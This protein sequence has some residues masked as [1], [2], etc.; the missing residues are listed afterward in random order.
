LVTPNVYNTTKHDTSGNLN[1]SA[2]LASLKTTKPQNTLGKNELVSKNGVA[3]GPLKSKGLVYRNQMIGK[4]KLDE[5]SPE[6]NID[7]PPRSYPTQ[8][9]ALGVI[10]NSSR[11][12]L[13]NLPEPINKFIKRDS[14]N[15]EDFL[16]SKE[17]IPCP[18]ERFS[19]G[20]EGFLSKN[21]H[22]LSTNADTLSSKVCEPNIGLSCFIIHCIIGTGSFGKV[23]LVQKKGTSNFYALKSLSKAQIFD[24]NL[25]RYAITERNVLRS[26]DHPFIVKLRYSFQ[27]SK[28]LFMV[29]EYMPGGDLGFYLQ[30]D[31]KFSERR[32]KIYAA[33][34]VLAISELHRHNIIFRDLKPDNI[35]LDQEGHIMLSDFGLSKENVRKDNKEMSFCGTFAYLAP[36]MVHK[37]G[38]GKAMD[39]YLLGALIYEM[40]TGTPPYYSEDKDELFENIKN[41]QLGFSCVISVE[42]KDIICCLLER[43]PKK[44]IKETAIKEHP[45]FRG[46]KWDDVFHRRLV[47][48]KP[49]IEK[50]QLNQIKPT[51]E[52]FSGNDTDRNNIVHW[53][54]VEEHDQETY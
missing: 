51:D 5:A 21:R 16:V 8:K 44:R 34:I 12:G 2:S 41:A 22:V 7:P 31:E 19:A 48:P 42:L 9:L 26:L 24:N 54:F 33:E 23:Y 4:R 43:D 47:P 14:P 35:L 53:T 38:H 40:V 18:A 36:E 17:S 37:A 6:T 45:W 3:S 20:R 13:R 39:W 50:R 30:R 49:F 27:N 15:I 11:I 52:I 10:P 29:M 28:N 1:T 46:I 32:A 25:T